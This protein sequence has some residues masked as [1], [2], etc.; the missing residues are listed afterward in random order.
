MVA[1]RSHSRKD[2][3]I[4]GDALVRTLSSNVAKPFWGD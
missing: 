2:K 1:S 4:D 3:G